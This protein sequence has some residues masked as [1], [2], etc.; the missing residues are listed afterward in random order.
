MFV[1][2]SVSKSRQRRQ[3]KRAQGGRQAVEKRQADQ[4]RRS[5]KQSDGSICHP[6]QLTASCRLHTEAD[7]ES[8]VMN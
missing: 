8:Q 5:V 1:T 7:C 6:L 3:T 2:D 4:N